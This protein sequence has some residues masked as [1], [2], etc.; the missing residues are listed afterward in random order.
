MN[1]L[2]K[3]IEMLDKDFMTQDEKLLLDDMIKDNPEAKKYVM[4]I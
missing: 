3:I 1:D 4:P 2:E